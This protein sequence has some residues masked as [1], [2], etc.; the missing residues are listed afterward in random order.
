[1]PASLPIALIVRTS[2]E[3]CCGSA[4]FFTLLLLGGLWRLRRRRP[5]PPPAAW[6]PLAIL[7][8]CEGAEPD[9]LDNLRSTGTAAYPGARRILFLV[10][11]RRDPAF[12]I[13]QSAAARMAADPRC[14]VEVVITEPRFDR[15]RKVEQLAVGLER[16]SEPVV[17]TIDSD[18]RLGDRDL[19]ALVA[20]LG[21]EPSAPRPV[22][23]AFAPPIEVAPRT[24]W[25]RASAALVGGS[26]QS[27][28][29][30]YGL[31]QLLG[32]VPK[33]AG[34]L[35]ALRRDVLDEIGGFDGVREYLG[36]D[37]EISR[38][39]LERGHDVALSPEP[40]ACTDGGRD[41]RSVLGRVVRW[42]TVVR[43]QRP[44]LLLT[45]PLFVAPTPSL[46]LLLALYRSP[47]LVVCVPLLLGAR[48]LLHRSLRRAQGQRVSV[49]EALL[50]V[51]AA[52]LLLLAGFVGACFTRHVRWRGHRFRVGAGG[53]LITDRRA[54]LQPALGGEPDRE[55]TTLA[56]PEQ[57]RAKGNGLFGSD[58]AEGTQHQSLGEQATD[59]RQ[60]R[61][62][63]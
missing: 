33:M 25:D 61:A 51:L 14:H 9:L 37:H 7:R 28:L 44:L 36:E 53:R 46:L 6:P 58:A 23:A 27:F 32:G 30:L 8:P 45:Y 41:L 54:P 4:L 62:P 15:N 40:A 20:A 11:S 50:G 35:C 1:M 13:A 43:A 16:C 12:A 22:A 42:L 47:F 48:V 18:V 17:V 49:A 2:F 3:V 19:P 5:A 59:Q 10:P 63:S 29:A 57:R 39:L 24:L 26:P 38:R 31:Q 60:L 56:R 55:G 34:A 52:E 21:G